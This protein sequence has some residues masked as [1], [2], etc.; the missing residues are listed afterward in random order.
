MYGMFRTDTIAG[1]NMDNCYLGNVYGLWPQ[2]AR[3]WER[4]RDSDPKAYGTVRSQYAGMIASNARAAARMVQ[5]RHRGSLSEKYLISQFHP[6]QNIVGCRFCF[7][8]P[9]FRTAWGG[10][11][12]Y[13][14]KGFSISS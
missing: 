9:T 1:L 5:Q 3:Q 11:I 2:T 10:A 6:F 13:Y 14:M 4:I 12:G 7:E 8:I